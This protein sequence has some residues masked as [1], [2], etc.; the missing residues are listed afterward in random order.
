MG[1]LYSRGLFTDYISDLKA[2]IFIEYYENHYEE[3][4]TPGSAVYDN[5]V[6]GFSTWGWCQ[7]D[8]ATCSL[9]RLI[10]SKINGKNRI[11]FASDVIEIVNTKKPV[12]YEGF[13]KLCEI[14]FDLIEK[15]RGQGKFVFK[16][17]K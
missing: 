5:V 9:A 14:A 7:L 17:P 1:N 3:L 15:D 12:N 10:F 11:N 8:P 16:D 2:R 6:R 13:H 4:T